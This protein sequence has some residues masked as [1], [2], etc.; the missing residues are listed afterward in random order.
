MRQ[1]LTE[2]FIAKAPLPITGDRIIYWD[3]ENKGLGLVVTANGHRSFVVQYRAGAHSR[4]MLLKN[5]RTLKEARK[6]AKVAFGEVAKQRDPLAEA[7][8]KASDGKNTLES[9]CEKYLG[10]AE[11]QGKLRSLKQRQAVLNRLVYPRLGKLPI[12]SIRRSDIVKLLDRI[13]DERGGSDGGGPMADVVLALLRRI[14]AWHA[15]QVD[16][17]NSPIVRGMARTAPHELK[18][19]RTLNDDELRAVWR[20]AQDS[21]GVFG[22]YVQFL[23]LTAVRRNEAANMSRKEL[24]GDNWLIPA[25]RYKTKV[26]M[27]VPL[28][29]AALAALARV[30]V[31]GRSDGFVF[32]TDGEKPMSAFSSL[33][34]QFDKACGVTGWTIHDLRRTASTLLNRAGV[35]P[36]HA[37]RCL[38][39][40]IGGVRGVYVRH[41]FEAEKRR[42]FEALAG[43]IERIINPQPNV[44]GL[45]RAAE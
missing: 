16:D 24:D 40:V 9:V 27:L 33:K 8:K 18:R 20:A 21:K 32:T 19:E 11:R 3:A 43:Q 29:R 31:I 42:A 1:K 34:R 41:D 28:S 17:F 15:V 2:P 36:D 39:H 45:R 7:R 5:A 22:P 44:V 25:A 14:M 38:G 37:E 26:D 23:L 10:H 13:E 4:R 6:A 30:P 35:S 12:D